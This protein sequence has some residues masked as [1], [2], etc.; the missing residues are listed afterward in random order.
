VDRK[1]TKCKHNVGLLLLIICDK[2]QQQQ[3]G[4]LRKGFVFII[5]DLLGMDGTPFH[6]S[7]PQNGT[8]FPE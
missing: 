5:K 3:S 8:S 1:H 2:K 7:P 4:G 6:E